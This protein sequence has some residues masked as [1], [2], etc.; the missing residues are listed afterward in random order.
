[1]GSCQYPLRALVIFIYLPPSQSF[2]NALPF[3]NALLFLFIILIC[4]LAKLKP[5]ASQAIEL[6]C[7]MLEVYSV[8]YSQIYTSKKACIALK[9]KETAELKRQSAIRR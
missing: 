4:P 5:L 7:E 1:M 9:Q 8:P 3:P 6:E 2:P